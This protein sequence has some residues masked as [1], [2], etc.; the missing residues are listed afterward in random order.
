M[1]AVAGEAR[2]TP[3][4][5]HRLRFIRR[6]GAGRAR[7]RAGLRCRSR[8]PTG[9]WARGGVGRP[10]IGAFLRDHR[11]GDRSRKFFVSFKNERSWRALVGAMTAIGWTEGAQFWVERARFG[12]HV[13]VRA[14]PETQ[15]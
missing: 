5:V 10:A 2:G 7:H 15:P 11:G 3:W 4:V 13:W 14:E 9:P 12:W 8:G 1:G 6:G